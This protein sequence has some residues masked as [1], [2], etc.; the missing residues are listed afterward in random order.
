MIAAT[1]AILCLEFC[2]T[3]TCI[4]VP[5]LPGQWKYWKFLLLAK[6]L[7]LAAMKTGMQD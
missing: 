5:G 7:V 4:S 6:P 2:L 3:G 1:V